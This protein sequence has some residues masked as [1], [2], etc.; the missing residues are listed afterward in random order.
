MKWWYKMWIKKKNKYNDLG[1]QWWNSNSK[2][3]LVVE[4]WRYAPNKWRASI[5]N[6]FLAKD[7]SKGEAITEAKDYMKRFK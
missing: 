1:I 3:S 7:V 2:S 6:T 5:N 4:V